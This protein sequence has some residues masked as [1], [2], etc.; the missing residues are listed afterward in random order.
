[1]NNEQLVYEE[2]NRAVQHLEEAHKLNKCPMCRADLALVLE[3]AIDLREIANF[4]VSLSSHPHRLQALRKLAIN[5]DKLKFLS[6][7]VLLYRN[8]FIRRFLYLG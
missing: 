6:L 1:M 3:A 4:A 7:M 5:L 8:K 2:I